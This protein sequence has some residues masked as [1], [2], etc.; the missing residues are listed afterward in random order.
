MEKGVPQIMDIT[1]I[2]S[3]LYNLSKEILPSKFE[4]AQQSES[5]TIQLGFRGVNKLIWVE[6]S[7]QGDCARIL[8]INKPKRFGTEST[9]AKQLSYGLK[10]LALVSIKQE[11]FERVIRF[12]FSKKPGSEIDKYLIIELMGKH[13]NFFFLD[14]NF[15]IITAGRQL[16]SSQSS[17]RKIATGI[18]YEEPPKNFKKEPDENESFETW[19]QN[20]LINHQTL[21]KSLIFNYQG[22]SPILTK[23]IE[24]ITKLKPKDIMNKDVGFIDEDNLKAIF[25]TWKKWITRIKNNKFNFST[26]NNYFYSVWFSLDENFNLEKF[27]I[28]VGLENYYNYFL[29]QKKIKALQLQLNKIIFKQINNEKKKFDLQD[30]LLKKSE[31]H[32]AYK[33]KADNIF[34]NI[35]LKKKDIIEAEKLYK[36]YKKLKRSQNQIKDRLVIHKNKLVRLDEF[37]T[38]LENLISMNIESNDRKIELLEELGY[39][40]SKEFILEK[41]P[42]LKAQKIN[43]ANITSYPIEIYSPGGLIIQIGRNMRQNDL[44]SFKYSKK[45]DLW[46]HAQESPGSHVVLK[47]S[48]KIATEEDIQIAADIS[49]LFCK[50]KGNIKV[51]ISLVKIKN[52]QKMSRIGAGCVSY[53]DFEIIWGYPARGEEYVKKNRHYQ[54]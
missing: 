52:L 43:S 46:F 29:N 25:K 13:S 38:M 14:K 26:F 12:E 9:L 37:N 16:K 1:S 19:K 47:A 48:A 7:W 39:E 24:F 5:N 42:L 23:Q 31:N 51:P 50:A 22:V 17:F 21:K 33:N 15:K 2:K 40:L 30:K 44:I 54:N 11:K 18:L 20:I 6:V 45:G 4:T 28:K 10:Y 53:K 41:K 36:K 32:E 49:A 27:E 3:T 8:E 35:N 34:L